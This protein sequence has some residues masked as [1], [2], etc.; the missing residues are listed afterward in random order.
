MS[1]ALL[2]TEGCVLQFHQRMGKPMTNKI[3]LV[4]STVTSFLFSAY[5]QALFSDIEIKPLGSPVLFDLRIVYSSESL[6]NMRT[7]SLRDIYKFQYKFC[8]ETIRFL[9]ENEKNLIFNDN[10][11]F[12]LKDD[13]VIGTISDEL[14][15]SKKELNSEK[16]SISYYKNKTKYKEILWDTVINKLAFVLIRTSNLIAEE[17]RNIFPLTFRDILHDINKVP[18]RLSNINGLFCNHQSNLTQMWAQ[19]LPI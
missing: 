16:L 5:G 6:K 9:L 10:D 2:N 8:I 1:Q 7:K 19:N 13:T 18:R 17:N 15:R 3:L 14:R 11:L 4:A 12:Y